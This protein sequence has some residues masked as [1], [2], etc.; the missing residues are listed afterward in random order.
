VPKASLMRRFRDDLRHLRRDRRGMLVVPGA[1]VLRCE[2]NLG[3]TATSLMGTS[4]TTGGAAATKGTAVQLIASTSFDAYWV[5]V[6]ASN[7]GVSA[8]TSRGC[9][10]LLIG[11]ATE[12]VLI[13]NMLMG[14]CGGIGTGTTN[15]CGPKV[16]DFPLYIPSGSRVAAQVAGDRT[17]TAMSVAVVLYGGNGSP[18]FPVG[19]SVTTY[20][21]SSV[22]GGVVVTSGASGAE[23]SWIEIAASSSR[24]HFAFVPSFQPPTG[25]TTLTPIKLF[26]MDMGVGAATEESMLGSEQSYVFRYDAGELCDG[27]F[28]PMPAFDVVPSGTRLVA[29]LSAN[30]ALDAAS[31]QCAIHG[32]S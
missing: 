8:T 1:G 26:W 13:A 32:V 3:N 30:G 24:E 27:P 20:G 6:I 18:A 28:N 10:D 14:F 2:H 29:R 15:G 19:A 17:S 25:D 16:W 7:Y 5:R 12:D 11:A 31:P 21:V 23:G 9:L 4:C 22:P